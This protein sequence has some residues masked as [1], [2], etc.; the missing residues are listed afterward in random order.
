[1]DICPENLSA[2]R[3]TKAIW[4]EV[5]PKLVTEHKETR[6]WERET[7]RKTRGITQRGRW[8]PQIN[9]SNGWFALSVSVAVSMLMP[10]SGHCNYSV[11][12]SIRW[13]S[14]PTLFPPGSGIPGVLCDLREGNAFGL[15]SSPSLREQSWSYFKFRS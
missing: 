13:P 1:M 11:L 2:A 6:K 4:R 14:Y 3:R 10:G 12:T 8:T 15:I 5:S 7:R 9:C